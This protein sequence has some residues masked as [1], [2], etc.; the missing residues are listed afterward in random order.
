M[1]KELQKLAE[2]AVSLAKKS[3]AQ[4][5]VAAA[6][7][8]RDASC[9]WRKGAWEKVSESQ[10]RGLGIELYVDGR[11]SSHSTSD[12]RLDSMKKFITEAVALTRALEP[13]PERQIPDPSLYQGR[14]QVDLQMVDPSC[15]AV[16]RDHRAG[17]CA[18]LEAV[19]QKG[20]QVIDVAA[21]I[22][23]GHWMSAKV[24]S[25][26]FSGSREGTS[27][28]FGCEATLS[29]GEKK[30]ADGYYV[31]SVRRMGLPEPAAVGEEALRRASA[32]LGAK[33]GPSMRATLVTVPEAGMNLVG[34]FLG[35]AHAAAVQQRRSFLAEKRGQQVGSPL[36][37]L[38][39]D[40]LIP[41]SPGSRLYDSEGIAAKVLPIV[42]DGILRDFYADTYYAR[43]LKWAPTTGSRSNLRLKLGTRDLLGLVADAGQG[44]LVTS[45]LGGN[46]D[47]TTGDFS[48][49]L[50]GHLIEGGKIGAPITEMNAT[51]NLL[52]LFGSLAAVG[53]DPHPYY[54]MKTPTLVFEGVEFSGA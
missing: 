9:T 44:I 17:V 10:S 43:K 52:K 4:D 14:P 7:W 19:V 11:Y 50:R 39:D 41:G 51:G 37:S 5:A 31:S 1:R 6:S 21:E 12:L 32:L 2:E 25:N 54:S 36:L 29:D 33:K 49:G 15:D 28:A 38:I 13:D 48:L 26:G 34:R 3:G 42:E 40:P 24:S 16:D 30:P 22:G 27:Y 46:A 45:W 53:N 18:A 35:A 23:D 20:S 8:S 47:P